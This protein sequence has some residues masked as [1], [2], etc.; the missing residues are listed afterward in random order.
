M[1][2]LARIEERHLL[3]GTFRR[4]GTHTTGIPTRPDLRP[5][6]STTKTSRP[7]AKGNPVR[8][9]HR[10]SLD[11]NDGTPF[12]EARWAIGRLNEHVGMTAP[13]FRPSSRQARRERVAESRRLLMVVTHN[14]AGFHPR[15]LLRYAVP[16]YGT[17]S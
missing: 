3:T 4:S 7:P 15:P 12:H 13:A 14:A 10:S 16:S 8:L 5:G 6:R 2:A 11:T 17:P 1:E 9:E